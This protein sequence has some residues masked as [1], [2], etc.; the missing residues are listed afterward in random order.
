MTFRHGLQAIELQF[1]KSEINYR[2]DSV[3]SLLRKR[4][5]AFEPDFLVGSSMGGY[6][7]YHLAAEFQLPALLFNPALHHRTTIDPPVPALDIIP[8]KIKVVIGENDDVVIPQ[9][10]LSW[11]DDNYRKKGNLTIATA[12]HSHRTPKDVFYKE[13]RLFGASC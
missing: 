6:L 1:D 8:P 3:Y 7:G 4:I 12:T 10:T 13:V 11:L 9:D 5:R 2:K